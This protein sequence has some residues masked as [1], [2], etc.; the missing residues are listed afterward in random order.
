MIV[1]F[2]YRKHFRDVIKG[3]NEA[4]SEIP[5]RGGNGLSGLLSLSAF[6]PPP[7]SLI[8]HGNPASSLPSSKIID[9]FENIGIH[10]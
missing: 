8:H 7:E 3:G 9:T 6:K 10:V 2:R 1:T 4:P 5:R